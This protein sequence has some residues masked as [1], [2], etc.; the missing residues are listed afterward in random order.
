MFFSVESS[1]CYQLL[2][3]KQLICLKGHVSDMYSEISG[4]NLGQN[5]GC[6]D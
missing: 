3:K 6:F 5:I 4:V 2:L 1:D